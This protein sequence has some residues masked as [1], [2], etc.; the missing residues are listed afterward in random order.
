MRERFHQFFAPTE[1]DF[2][3]MWASGLFSFDANVLLNIYRYS[4]ET[5]ESLI[6]F[7]VSQAERIRLPHQFALEF[8]RNRPKVI[9]GQSIKYDSAFKIF[10][11]FENEIGS[12]REHP[13][14]TE[15][16][17]AAMTT[18]KSELIENRKKLE[19]LIS[20]DNYANT[21]DDALSTKIGSEPKQEAW[22]KMCV[23]AAERF[24]NSVPPG[25]ADAKD[26][27]PPDCYG[28][29]IAWNQLIAICSEEKRDLILV[30]DDTKEDWWRIENGRTIGPRPE[31]LAEFREPLIN[32]TLA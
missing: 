3:E 6:N 28:D 8:V 16:A 29:Y 4:D 24:K 27:T 32:R 22:D 26:K 30:T 23:E 10:E 21:L 2:R 20:S 15:A 12:R 9:V 18:L 11:K 5:K 19:G 14:L 7:I 31:L 17:Q 25:F 13:H 1:S